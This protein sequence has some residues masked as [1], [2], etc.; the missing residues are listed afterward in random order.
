M[1]INVN[2]TRIGS[3]L[4]LS[5]LNEKS[6]KT[7]EKIRSIFGEKEPIAATLKIS[8]EGKTAASAKAE[9]KQTE[10]SG[11][12]QQ[13]KPQVTLPIRDLV[14]TG[15][16]SIDNAIID[17]LNGVS[18]E[19]RQ[20]AYDIVRHDF[21]LI[22]AEGISE[23]ERQDLISLGLS[24]AQ[25]V[26]DNYLSGDNAKIFMTAMKKVAGIAASGEREEDG[27][28]DYNIIY[29]TDPAYQT[30]DGHTSTQGSIDMVKMMKRYRPEMYKEFKALQKE[31]KETEDGNQHDLVKQSAMLLIRFTNEIMAEQPEAFK[32]FERDGLRRLEQA[33]DKD[34]K[35][36]FRNVDTK[37]TQNFI[38]ALMQMQKGNAFSSF[39]TLTSR[40]STILGQLSSQTWQSDK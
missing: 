22:K 1:N 40:I 11:A 20:Y 36:T 16:A 23:D 13:K 37:G 24:E 34:V 27:T 21:L 29:K 35:P 14:R 30:K 7:D 18:D 10:Q 39:P 38:Q 26:A 5:E 4:D 6:K 31:L 33:S 25:Y 19:V 15:Y 9:G 12:V 3:L 32:E 17:S 8:Q 28:M 2:D